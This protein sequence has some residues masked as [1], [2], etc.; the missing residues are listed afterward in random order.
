MKL[1]FRNKQKDK[2]TSCPPKVCNEMNCLLTDLRNTQTALK[3]TKNHIKNL[4][5]KSFPMVCKWIVVCKKV[6]DYKLIN[7]YKLSPKDIK[8]IFDITESDVKQLCEEIQ[9]FFTV[10]VQIDILQQQ[11]VKLEKIEKE[12]KAKLSIT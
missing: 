4:Y 6:P 5:Q 9:D 3:T 12:L 11:I 2:E 7:A 8:I 10:N 1:W